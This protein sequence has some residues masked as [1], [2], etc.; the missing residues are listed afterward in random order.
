MITN[1]M[2]KVVIFVVTMDDDLAN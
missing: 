1:I 2:V